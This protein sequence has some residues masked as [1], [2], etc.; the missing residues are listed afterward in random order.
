[1]RMR[2]RCKQ[3]R[4]VLPL[5][6]LHRRVKLAILRRKITNNGIH[7]LRCRAVQ[8]VGADVLLEARQPRRVI[9]RQRPAA[10]GGHSDLNRRGLQSCAIGPF[11]PRRAI[12]ITKI[13]RIKFQI[14][15]GWMPQHW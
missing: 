9:C 11:I 14:P 2:G 13:A 8:Q 12:V 1:M 15:I 7:N 3:P 6:C 5:N 4:L 10:Q